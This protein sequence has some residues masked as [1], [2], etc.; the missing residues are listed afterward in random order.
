LVDAG[1]LYAGQTV[2]RIHH[3]GSAAELVADLTP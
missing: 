1:P 3:I 2:A